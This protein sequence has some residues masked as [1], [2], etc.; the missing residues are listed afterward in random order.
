MG[1]GGAWGFLQFFFMATALMACA[2]AFQA[3]AA[4]AAPAQEAL[5]FMQDRQGIQYRETP[6][7]VLAFYYPWYG[8]QERQGHWVHW[9]GVDIE[10][11]D[12]QSSTHYPA[13]GAYDSHDPA[14]VD[15]HFAWAKAAGIDGLIVSWWGPGDF[16]DRAMPLLL[17]RAEAHGLKITV[18]W[19]DV[20]Q[21]TASGRI[22]AGIIDLGYL[23]RQYGRHPAFLKVDKKPV[24]F[25]YG[26]VMGQVGFAEWPAI[27]RGA[28]AAFGGPFA[29]IADGPNRG[30]AALFD[31]I[32]TYNPVGWVAAAPPEALVDASRKT[33]AAEV[34]LARRAGKVAAVTVIPGYDDTKI[35]KPGLM[36]DRRDGRTYETLWR[37][38]IA[39]SP[40]WILIT[41]F[42]EWHEGSEIEPSAEDGDVYLDLT[43]RM[44]AAF[45]AS[46]RPAVGGDAA[47]GGLSPAQKAALKAA[48]QGKRI[49]VLPDLTP[50]SPI[51]FWLGEA[52]IPLD[53]LDRE[54]VAAGLDP[55]ETPIVLYA[56]GE[57][58]VQTEREPLDVLRGLQAYLRRGGLLIAAAS[59]PL[60]FYYDGSGKAVKGDTA[61]GFRIFG[62]GQQPL[63]GWEQPPTG[64]AL[65]FGVNQEA[66]PL[67]PARL[68]FP[69]GGDLRWRPMGRFGLSPSD[70]YTPLVTLEGPEGRSFGD[71]VAYVE[72]R[73]SEPVG[74]RNLY[75]WFR[76]L[77]HPQADPLLAA[78][79][80]FAADRATPAP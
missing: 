55:Q 43:R 23:L 1:R 76:L 6:R 24:I 40:D 69:A 72:H 62:T 41:S 53:F 71:A 10:R 37:A 29:L 9:E 70:V 65:H 45:K 12:I 3:R 61:L 54:R 16:T 14:I 5:E 44:T 18:Y 75:V 36:A 63:P 27:V 79:F 59:L 28:E 8:S 47:A 66:L 39:A 17:A 56:G 51:V 67:L 64:V 80:Q 74:G 30:N 57:H 35:R 33:Y 60:P 46:A 78:V 31:G 38:A 52:G 19:E 15:Q 68:D 4:A 32:H 26:R 48:F 25:V 11:R 58:F 73:G 50:I 22:R 20:P 21:K 49:G 7:Q 77:D 42:N 34:Q 2:L 13:L